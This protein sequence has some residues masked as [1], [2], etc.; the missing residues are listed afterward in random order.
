MSEER[1]LICKLG[2]MI[3]D[4]AEV[5]A[6]IEKITKDSPEYIGLSSVVTDEMAEIALAMGRRKPT[7][8]EKLG[9][10]QLMKFLQQ[11]G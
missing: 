10:P 7:T 3:T 9:N 6:G 5:I 11:R 4:R 8:P 2:K 1:K